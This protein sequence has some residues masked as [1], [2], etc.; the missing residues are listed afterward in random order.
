MTGGR[1]SPLPPGEGQG[2]GT[3]F[4]LSR[5]SAIK[6]GGALVVAFALGSRLARSATSA[7]LALPV[8]G[9]STVPPRGENMR[10]RQLSSPLAGRA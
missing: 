7:P 3:R 10:A 2:E 5:R 9:S 6:A 4:N 1:A 8:A